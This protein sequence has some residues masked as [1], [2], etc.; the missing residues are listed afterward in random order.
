[1]GENGK[2]LLASDIRSELLMRITILFCKQELP[3]QTHLPFL[4]NGRT[5][6]IP[7]PQ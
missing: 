4:Q 3:D 1:M 7:L 5:G 2:L 6:F